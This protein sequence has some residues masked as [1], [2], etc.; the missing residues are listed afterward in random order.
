MLAGIGVISLV[1]LEFLP[2][3]DTRHELDA[4]QISQTKNRQALGMGVSM[5]GVGLN[6]RVV[7]E[8]A[9][10]E[11]ERLKNTTGYEMAE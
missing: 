11:I 9:I 7:V 6:L 4:Q 1:E 10:E 5:E 8:Q 2:I 3:S